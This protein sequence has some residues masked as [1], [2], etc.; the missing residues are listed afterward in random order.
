MQQWRQYLFKILMLMLITLVSISSGHFSIKAQSGQETLQPISVL[1][2]Y[3]GL[4][5]LAWSPDG[6]TLAVGTYRGIAIYDEEL[7]EIGF[8]NPHNEIQLTGDLIWS[9]E[10]DKLFASN[11]FISSGIQMSDAVYIWDM[12]NST[13][14][15]TLPLDKNVLAHA[16][17]WN[18]E[19]NRILIML[20]TE[21]LAQTL[22]LWNAQ[23][24]EVQEIDISALEFST[25]MTWSWSDDEQSLETI[26]GSDKFTISL[27]NIDL[28]EQIPV[29]SPSNTNISVSPDKRNQ[30]TIGD[31]VKLTNSDGYS[32]ELTDDDDNR[33]T[34]FTDVNWSGNSNRV[35]VWGRRVLPNVI[36]AD[37]LTGEILLEFTY[38]QV[39][40]ITSAH[41]NLDGSI[42]ALTSFRDEL[43]VYNFE[44]NEWHQRWFNGVSTSL[45][46]NPDGSKIAIVNGAS[47]NVYIW[48]TLTGE[49]VE[50]WQ[51]P[52]DASEDTHNIISVAW[53]PDGNYVATGSFAG[54]RAENAE[55]NPIDLFIWSAESGEVVNI[56]PAVV[57]DTD[58]ISELEWSTDSQ[59]IAYATTSIQR[60]YSHIGAYSVHDEELYFQ[61][62]LS[63]FVLDMALHP[64]GEIMAVAVV[65][66]QETS[67]MRPVLFIDVETGEIVD[68]HTPKIESG[69]VS[70]DWHPSGNYLA[71]RTEAPTP[72]EIWTLD[73]DD[74]LRLHM[75][76]AISDVT[77]RSV[78]KW[79]IEGNYL[80]LRYLDAESDKLGIQIWNLNLEDSIA[81]LAYL[82]V[83]SYPDYFPSQAS[84]QA[85]NWSRD[86]RYIA[87][88]LSQ[89]TS[90]VWEIPLIE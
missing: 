7:N 54:S 59:T 2:N 57:Y 8:L 64:D 32:F 24:G 78:L 46:F 85:L 5:N 58:S 56:V 50:V 6:K 11:N 25:A 74:S 86:G 16:Q 42:V 68:I 30:A 3:G 40:S 26:V 38:D 37:V 73:S 90:S 48:D 1:G 39:G 82:L 84:I 12:V 70:I 44:K 83:P 18:K 17:A 72:I 9:P 51:T 21:S 69:V 43:L 61:R 67:D 89:F 79:N 87:A 47:Q 13:I 45:S 77:T 63:A 22:L 66:W 31:T 71:V 23:T 55:S 15:Y 36:V 35:A 65:N 81:E 34:R 4:T 52:N 88:N 76:F 60:P 19:G 10:G 27:E 53:S 29:P 33:F 28:I 62:R 75:K 80:A 20:E 14:L 49:A 41:L